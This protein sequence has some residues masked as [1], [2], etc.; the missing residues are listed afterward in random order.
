MRQVATKG[1]LTVVATSG[2]IAVGGGLAYADAGATG[3]ATGSPGVLSGN[4]VQVPVH[5]PINLCGNTLNILGV[6]NPAVGDSCGNASAPGGS[7][8]AAGGGSSSSPGVGSG[9]TVQAPVDVPVNTCGNTVTV[10]GALSGVGTNSCGGVEP[11]PS[12][13]GQP[14]TPGPPSTPVPPSTPGTPDGPGTPGAPGSPGTSANR[15]EGDRP[16]N[17]GTAPTSGDTGTHLVAD[18]RP[19]SAGTAALAHTGTTALGLAVPAGALLFGGSVLY[20][21]GRAVARR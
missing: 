13:P 3:T 9:N 4:S 5:V 21:R 14:G 6:L 19:S 16:G 17:S 11:G 20:R 8:A 15:G 1:L 2:M 18:P 7:G 12:D 10:V